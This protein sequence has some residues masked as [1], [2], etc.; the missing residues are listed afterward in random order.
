MRRDEEPAK[1][2]QQLTECTFSPET[3]KAEKCWDAKLTTSWD[4]SLSSSCPSGAGLLQQGA[5]SSALCKLWSSTTEGSMSGLVLLSP[6]SL[7]KSVKVIQR[8]RARGD[9]QGNSGVT[10]GAQDFILSI[11]NYWDPVR[12][13]FFFWSV[14]LGVWLFLTFDHTL[15]CGVMLISPQS[16]CVSVCERDLAH[17]KVSWGSG[18]VTAAES[19][20]VTCSK[21]ACDITDWTQSLWGRP[22]LRLMCIHK[23]WNVET[24]MLLSHHKWQ[25]DFLRPLWHV[26]CTVIFVYSKN[27]YLLESLGC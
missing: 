4:L 11:T 25:K 20:V 17:G 7:P 18:C 19:I 3:E 1:C 12:C 16:V 22:P 15:S 13:V 10:K 24:Q 21:E 6:V 14:E 9:F 8:K 27:R 5:D 26:D 23:P 2:K